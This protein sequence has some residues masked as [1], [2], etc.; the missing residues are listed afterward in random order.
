MKSDY[1]SNINRVCHMADNFLAKTAEHHKECDECARP[2][3][4][5][6]CSG[7]D[8]HPESCDCDWTEEE[9]SRE[10]HKA[11]LKPK[12]NVSDHC[13]QVLAEKYQDMEPDSEDF[14]IQDPLPVPPIDDV[15][16]A[17]VLLDIK[18]YLE[19]QCEELSD[20]DRSELVRWVVRKYSPT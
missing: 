1:I 9:K 15:S 6:K 20:R 13:L 18:R 19:D 2:V 16:S 14:R 4:N 10:L 7:C 12:A 5:G 17:A 8:K 11:H 3:R